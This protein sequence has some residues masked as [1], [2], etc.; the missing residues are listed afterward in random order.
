MINKFDQYTVNY[1]LKE[2]KAVVQTLKS[3]ALST[4]GQGLI[5]GGKSAALQGS[6]CWKY[7]IQ[8]SDPGVQ[9][10]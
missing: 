4:A 7:Y 10:F 6:L 1:D 9:T 2:A 8:G 5:F 3:A